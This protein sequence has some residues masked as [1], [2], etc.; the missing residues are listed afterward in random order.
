MDR[1]QE[2]FLLIAGVLAIVFSNNLINGCVDAV[3]VLFNSIRRRDILNNSFKNLCIKLSFFFSLI[4]F[5]F[6]TSYGGVSPHPVWRVA[7]VTVSYLV[8]KEIVFLLSS[9]FSGK[10]KEFTLAKLFS[11][12]AFTLFF[13]SS[14]PVA[15]LSTFSLEHFETVAIIYFGLLFAY[16]F[17]VYLKHL[18]KILISSGFSLFSAFLYLCAFELLPTVVAIKELIS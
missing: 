8:L 5:V 4:L 16:F 15:A 18:Y 12:S 6:A 1:F 9:W 17:S 3:N 11:I 10:K 14:L 7:A 2:I 13:W